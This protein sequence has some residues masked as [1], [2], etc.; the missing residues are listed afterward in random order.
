MAPGG[1]GS[2]IWIKVRSTTCDC[3][4]P[5]QGATWPEFLGRD[6]QATFQMNNTAS[7]LNNSVKNVGKRK[8]EG[9][10][11]WNPHRSWPKSWKVLRNP[12]HSPQAHITNDWSARNTRSWNEAKRW[13][14]K[15]KNNHPHLTFYGCGVMLSRNNVWR[16]LFYL[17]KNAQGK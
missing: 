13:A 5:N 7:L 3:C 1:L 8:W 6:T 15:N 11:A 2:A 16:W 10:W 14:S 4:L 9:Q 17:K 12:P